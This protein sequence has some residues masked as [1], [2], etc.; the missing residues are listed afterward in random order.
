MLLRLPTCLPPLPS[1][2]YG[3]NNFEKQIPI[4]HKKGKKKDFNINKVRFKVGNL[5]LHV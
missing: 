1:Y 4:F 5:Y 2:F 3:F